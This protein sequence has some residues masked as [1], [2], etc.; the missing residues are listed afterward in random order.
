MHSFTTEKSKQN[1]IFLPPSLFQASFDE[2]GAISGSLLLFAP[3]L[4]PLISF[5]GNLIKMGICCTHCT[6]RIP[7]EEE[8]EDEEDADLEPSHYLKMIAGYEGGRFSGPAWV[9]KDADWTTAQ[10]FEDEV[11]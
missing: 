4:G 1:K 2:N 7:T 10:Y 8:E 5:T 9:S 3:R 6:G 11:V